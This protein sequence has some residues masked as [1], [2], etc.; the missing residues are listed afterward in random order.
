MIVVDAEIR[1]QARNEGY[2][3]RGK[4]REGQRSFFGLI[5]QSSRGDYYIILI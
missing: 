5:N 1:N 3:C 2:I 4:V